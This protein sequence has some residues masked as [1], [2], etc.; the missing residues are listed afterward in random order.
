M[1]CELNTV[2]IFTVGLEIRT[3]R[4]AYSEIIH[5]SMFHRFSVFPHYTDHGYSLSAEVNALHPAVLG[6]R[7]SDLLFPE[8]ARLNTRTLFLVSF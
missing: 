8:V 7:L 2:N 5:T 1:D 3:H 6:L 4:A